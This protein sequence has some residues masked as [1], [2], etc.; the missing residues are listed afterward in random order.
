V[1]YLVLELAIHVIKSQIHLVRQ[2][3]SGRVF[4]V[5]LIYR[6]GCSCSPTIELSCTQRNLTLLSPCLVPQLNRPVICTVEKA[7][8]DGQI[9]SYCI[10]NLLQPNFSRLPLKFTFSVRLKL[11]E[12]P[13]KLSYFQR[14]FL[15]CEL[16]LL[17]VMYR[18]YGSLEN[19]SITEV[20]SYTEY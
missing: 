5:Y 16:A 15:A 17:K 9:C 20:T 1:P 14:K 10:S 7:P 2:P 19:S 6:M 8:W 4:F 13:P 12:N 11:R 18:R 3:L